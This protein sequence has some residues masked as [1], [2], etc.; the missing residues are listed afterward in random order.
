M[1]KKNKKQALSYALGTS[2]GVSLQKDEQLDIDMSLPEINTLD[3]IQ[4]ALEL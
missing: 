4:I 2:K 1:G 3:I